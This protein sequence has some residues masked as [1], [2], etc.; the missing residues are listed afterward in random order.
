MEPAPP[1]AAADQRRAKKERR[2]RIDPTTFE[3]Q[4]TADEMEFMNAMQRFKEAS[5]KSFPT[6]GEV[7]KVAVALGY[8]RVIDDPEPEWDDT[9]DNGECL[10]DATTVDALAKVC[11][12]HLDRHCTAL[13]SVRLPRRE[14]V[15]PG[16]RPRH[17]PPAWSAEPLA[18]RS[19][20]RTVRPSVHEGRTRVR[21]SDASTR[22][23]LRGAKS[24]VVYL[25]RPIRRAP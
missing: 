10:A 7:L 19:A 13:V 9:T 17:I 12:T 22:P 15:R 4:Y 14:A 16:D 8:R 2:R 11:R 21:P 5:G 1:P 25:Q 3:K 23:R 24:D 18:T 6:H 20:E